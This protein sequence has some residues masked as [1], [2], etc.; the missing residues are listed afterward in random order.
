M[1]SNKI[2]ACVPALTCCLR[3]VSHLPPGRLGTAPSLFPTLLVQGDKS[4]EAS[5]LKSGHNPVFRIHWLLVRQRV[6]FEQKLPQLFSPLKNRM[7]LSQI[8]ILFLLPIERPLGVFA[9]GIPGWSN[10]ISAANHPQRLHPPC[11]ALPAQC[12]SH[13]CRLMGVAYTIP[14]NWKGRRGPHP[15]VIDSLCNRQ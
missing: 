6:L 12:I 5:V 13:C 9:L 10:S 11:P 15:R 3:G 14:H 4:E 1:G 7:R 8:H 2:D